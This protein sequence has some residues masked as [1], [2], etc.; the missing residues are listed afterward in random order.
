MTAARHVWNTTHPIIKNP[1][2]R[3]MLKEPIKE[4]LKYI[5]VVAK[6]LKTDNVSLLYHLSY[7]SCAGI[8]HGTIM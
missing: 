5:E 7:L 4:V 6:Y 8:K 1:F 3:Q 2:D